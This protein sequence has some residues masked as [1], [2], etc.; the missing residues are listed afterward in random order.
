MQIEK[1]VGAVHCVSKLKRRAL[2]ISTQIVISL[3]TLG[4]LTAPAVACEKSVY[5]IG[6]QAI[7]YSPHYNF[8]DKDAANYFGE[9]VD[10]LN[11]KLPCTFIVKSLPIR[12]LNFL[13]EQGMID[14][15]YPDN[16]SWH[17]DITAGSRVY[18]SSLVTALGGT[19][20]KHEDASI[21]AL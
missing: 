13:F 3:A 10:W 6:V 15:I 7:D 17:D 2:S 12:R 5:T 1:H 8:N 11:K 4:V 20:V 19:V 16:P 18:S 21:N 14:F 9:Y